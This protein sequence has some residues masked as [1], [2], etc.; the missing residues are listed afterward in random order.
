[1]R[2]WLQPAI[3][4][5]NIED[6]YAY[7]NTGSTTAALV[8]FVHRVTKMLEQNAYVRCLM[9]DFSKAFDSVDHVILMSKLTQLNLPSYVVNWI[10]SFLA[11]R[12]QQCKVNGK[13][14]MVACIGR[15]IVQGSGIGPTLYI[16]MKS[17]LHALSKLNDLF[18]YADDTTLLVPEHTDTNISVEF[19]HV[20]AWASTNHL[21]LNL[22]KTKEI[23]FKRPRVRCFHLPHAIDE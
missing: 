19:S 5:E 6:Q 8:H 23:V 21:T 1:V 3:P 2:R 13:L 9:I 17:D 22:L 4:A 10:C 14:S 12:G 20:K 7:K 11:G 15:S 18:K 16:V